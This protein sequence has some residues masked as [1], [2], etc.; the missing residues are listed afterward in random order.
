MEIVSPYLMLT[1][2]NNKLTSRPPESVMVPYSK[3]PMELPH[4]VPPSSS[5]S[6]SSYGV[7]CEPPRMAQSP[8][9]DPHHAAVAMA[10][11]N[12]VLNSCNPS[13]A[14]VA[15][16]NILGHSRRSHHQHVSRS[17]AYIQPSVYEM[18]ALTTDLDTQ[19]ITCKIKETLMAHNIGQKVS[20]LSLQSAYIYIYVKLIA[21]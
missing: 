1:G 21:S 5:S 19:T 17:P 15:A 9:P 8:S 18:A 4:A 16:A 7:P 6:S 14:A 2:S 13:A 11:N 12:S 20:E 10:L 3:P